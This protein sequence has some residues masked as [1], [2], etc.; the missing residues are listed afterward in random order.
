MQAP[1]ILTK[2]GVPVT[3]ISKV[4]DIVANDIGTN[5]SCVPTEECMR[6]TLDAIKNRSDRSF[7]VLGQADAGLGKLIPVL[8]YWL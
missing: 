8:G 5:I 6:L 2:A 4:V 7:T 3:L 1:T